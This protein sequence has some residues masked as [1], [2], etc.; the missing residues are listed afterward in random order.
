MLWCKAQNSQIHTQ[1]W[2]C[3]RENRLSDG[4]EIVRA[5][6]IIKMHRPKWTVWQF[7]PT[8]ETWHVELHYYYLGTTQNQNDTKRWLT[9]AKN[10]PLKLTWQPKMPTLSTHI[11]SYLLFVPFFFN[12]LSPN[13]VYLC[14]MHYLKPN[15][16]K[17][18]FPPK[19]KK[20]KIVEPK[21]N[22]LVRICGF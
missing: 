8:L 9:K 17:L 10:R 5:Q 2:A 21:I 1:T 12:L 7:S 14:A 22:L 18:I 13:E 3:L 20:K 6:W 4:R 16:I 11:L 15:I 19:K